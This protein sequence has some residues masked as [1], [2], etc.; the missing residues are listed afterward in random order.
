MDMH[1][2]ARIGIP[3]GRRSKNLLQHNNTSFYNTENLIT[4]AGYACHFRSYEMKR[5]YLKY[6]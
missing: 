5:D 4:Y 1:S 2:L 6:T 3:G